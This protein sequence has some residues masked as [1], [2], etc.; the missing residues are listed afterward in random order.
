MELV[1]LGLGLGLAAGV[2][3]GPLLALV[4]ASSLERGFGAGLRVA[5]APLLSDA[6]VIL[7]TLLVLRELS[8]SL[9]RT[10]AALGGALVI[11]LAVG[12]W[13]APEDDFQQK[14]A[15][16][17]RELWRG[18]LVNLLNPHPWVGWATVLGP[19]LLEAWRHGPSRGV[20]FVGAFY[21]AIV[22]SKAA[23]AWIVARGGRRLSAAGRR[24]LLRGSGLL[25]AGLGGLL[26]WRALG[27]LP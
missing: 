15:G 21:A 19:T 24:Q 11:L 18:V 23:I 3:P 1:A 9:L 13:R 22:A 10:L 7:L 12:F 5:L 20:A 6:P 8:P 2:S 26:L 17:G 4:V 25:L 16:S 14:A 27:P